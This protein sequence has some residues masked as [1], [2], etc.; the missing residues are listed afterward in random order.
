[1]KRGKVLFSLLLVL[2]L[3]ATLLVAPASAGKRGK[4]GKSQVA[5]T[6]DIPA[7]VFPES[8]Q[9]PEAAESLVSQPDS[10]A[11]ALHLVAAFLQLTP[12]QVGSLKTLLRQR[13]QAIVPLVQEIVKRQQEIHLQLNSGSP[14]PATLGQLLIEIHEFLQ[15]V[16][17]AQE[18]FLQAFNNLLN[19]EQQRRYGAIRVAERLQPFLAAF[20]SLRLI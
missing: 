10:P 17:Q 8:L 9:V 20:Q 4:R 5:P 19:E 12:D 14:D 1:M 18:T 11:E 15:L 16:R 2:V 7:S 3:C 6:P 13:R